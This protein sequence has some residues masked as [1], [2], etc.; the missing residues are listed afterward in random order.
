MKDAK[1]VDFFQSDYLG[2]STLIQFP[3][4][5]LPSYK[6]WPCLHIDYFWKLIQ[7]RIT[8]VASRQDDWGWGDGIS[9]NISFYAVTF[10]FITYSKSKIEKEKP[11]RRN[12]LIAK[13]SHIIMKVP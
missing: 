7:H 6:E 13:Y 3:Y 4:L 12:I 9:H 2:N 5:Y 8:V 10:V 11:L 1:S